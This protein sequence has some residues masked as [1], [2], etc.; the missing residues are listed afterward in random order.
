MTAAARPP[1][2]ALA[3]ASFTLPYP[4]ANF[5][6]P[7]SNKGL[8]GVGVR[9]AIAAPVRPGAASPEMDGICL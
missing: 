8:C 3:P 2:P 4:C 1:F 5:P 9:A 6:V 7:R